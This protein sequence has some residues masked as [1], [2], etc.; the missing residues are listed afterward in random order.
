MTLPDLRDRVMKERSPVVI[1]FQD[2]AK[3]VDFARSWA[4]GHWAVVVGMNDRF[5]YLMDPET[6]AARG[7][8]THRQLLERWHGMD[9]ETRVRGLGVV[10]ETDLQPQ[11]RVFVE[12]SQ[13]F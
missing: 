7:R 5:V 2:P 9:E 11:F 13:A 8:L 1:L 3:K 6:P 12:K 10:V 4:N